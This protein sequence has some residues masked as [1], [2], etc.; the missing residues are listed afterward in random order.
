MEKTVKKYTITAAIIIAV[1][2]GFFIGTQYDKDYAEIMAVTGATPVALADDIPCSISLKITGLVKK[3][4]VLS[5]DALN[6]LAKTRI[7]T[8]ELA[9]DG[10]LVGTYAYLGVPVINILE[11]IAPSEFKEGE[12]DKPL[13]FL[14]VFSSASGESINFSYGE[15][16]FTDDALPVTLA[17]DRKEI[18]ASKDPEKYDKNIYKENLTGLR[19]ICPRDKDTSRYLDDVEVITFKRPEISYGGLPAQK[20]GAKCSSGSITCVVDNNAGK[21]IFSGVDRIKKKDWFRTGH[22]RGFKSVSDAE[23]YSLRSFLRKNFSGCGIEDYF[24]FVACDGYRCLFS[25]REI[26]QHEDGESMMILGTMDGK[27]APGGYMLAP[28]RDYFVDRDVWGLSHIV[29]VENI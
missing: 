4:Y 7:R 1:L 23:G 10:K 14:V 29:L 28:L 16:I 11:G 27:P 25:G 12:Y 24:L 2:V 21:A 19:L 17:Y 18:R 13:D 6:A 5:G 8:R 9:P 20:K 26:F 3:E 22:G 15:L